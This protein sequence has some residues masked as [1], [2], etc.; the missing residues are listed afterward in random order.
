MRRHGV[1]ARPRGK[2]LTPV[3]LLLLGVPVAQLGY[4]RA[5]P[6]ADKSKHRTALTMVTVIIREPPIDRRKC[7]KLTSQD[8]GVLPMISVH[9]RTNPK[10]AMLIFAPRTARADFVSP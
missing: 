1:V 6:G 3:N 8:A 9:V 10:M 2:A 4:T 7:K 5:K